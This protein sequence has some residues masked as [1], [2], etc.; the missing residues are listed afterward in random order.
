M[1]NIMEVTSFTQARRVK[2]SPFLTVV[3]LTPT[4]CHSTSSLVK[5]RS[6]QGDWLPQCGVGTVLVAKWSQHCLY[7][8]HSPANQKSVN[9][10]RDGDQNTVLFCLKPM[11]HFYLSLPLLWL[12]MASVGSLVQQAWS[13][14]LLARQSPPEAQLL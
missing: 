1:V 5:V 9:A 3:G 11:R 10:S 13:R 2:L 7:V 14:C 6:H 12:Q 4:S 8:V